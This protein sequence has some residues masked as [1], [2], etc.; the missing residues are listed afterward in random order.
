ME[1]KAIRR[2]QRARKLLV[3]AIYQW[4]LS[5]AEPVE[6]AAQFYAINDMSKIDTEHFD[7]LIRAIPKES[8]S[9]NN[10]LEKYLDRS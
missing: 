10:L 5:D 6:I 8:T 3:Q 1:K 4:L 2:K 7:N 9:I